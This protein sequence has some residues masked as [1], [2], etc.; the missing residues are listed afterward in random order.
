MAPLRRG[1]GDELTVK[2]SIVRA[3]ADE[4][5]ACA[6]HV[7]VARESVDGTVLLVAQ[8]RLR[9]AGQAYALAKRELGMA[10]TNK[11]REKQ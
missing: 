8:M 3:L 1:E 10:M 11:E 7:E 5:L 4:V 2:R 6:E 9:R